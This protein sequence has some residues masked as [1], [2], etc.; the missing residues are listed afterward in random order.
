MG[1]AES[2]RHSQARH[3]IAAVSIVNALEWF[4]FAVFG[5][6]AGTIAKVFFPI[7]EESLSLLAAFATFGVTFLMRPLGA[8]VIGD[9]ADRRGRKAGLN[10]TIALML[11]GT[12]IIAGAPTYSSIGVLAPILIIAARMLQGFSAGGEFGSA[13]AFLHQAGGHPNNFFGH[14]D[15]MN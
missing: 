6:L 4:D 9:F 2:L 8:I 13:T 11:I 3:A 5:Y 7:A 14:A 12:A 15:V 1:V 10:L